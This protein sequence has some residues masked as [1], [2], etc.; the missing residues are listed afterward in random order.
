[1]GLEEI[2]NLSEP[3]RTGHWNYRAFFRII[4]PEIYIEYQNGNPG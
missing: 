1:M 2:Q 4:R 3:V